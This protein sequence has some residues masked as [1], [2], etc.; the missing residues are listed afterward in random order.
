VVFHQMCAPAKFCTK[1]YFLLQFNITTDLF[2]KVSAT[3][4]DQGFI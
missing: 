3:P 1:Y 2:T 4:P